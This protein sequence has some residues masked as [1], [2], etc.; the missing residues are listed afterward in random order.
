MEASAP[1]GVDTTIYVF[2]FV[3]DIYWRFICCTNHRNASITDGPVQ[4][5]VFS[6]KEEAGQLDPPARLPNHGPRILRGVSPHISS[7][8]PRSDFFFFA[9]HAFALPS[10]SV[11]RAARSLGIILHYISS[12]NPIR[13]RLPTCFKSFYLISL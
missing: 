9:R 6:L 13:Q 4:S 5:S 3:F 12:Q 2:V 8:C 10:H 11:P 7:I 1:S